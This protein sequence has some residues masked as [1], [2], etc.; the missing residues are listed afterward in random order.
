MEEVFDKSLTLEAH[1]QRESFYIEF[2]QSKDVIEKLSVIGIDY[3]SIVL[4]ER[5]VDKIY[6]STDWKEYLENFDYSRE[7]EEETIIKEQINAYREEYNKSTVKELGNTKC[8]DSDYFSNDADHDEEDINESNKQSTNAYKLKPSI[9]SK[10]MYATNKSISSKLKDSFC[11]VKI[12]PEMRII[13]WQS[14]IEVILR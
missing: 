10:K 8:T 11:E 14:T 6:E 7:P 9:I 2:N 1:D 13:H 12:N 5:P 3:E 4:Q